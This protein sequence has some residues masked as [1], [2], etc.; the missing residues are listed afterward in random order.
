MSVSTLIVINLRGP[1]KMRDSYVGPFTIIKLV[2]KKEVEVNLTEE[3]SRKHPFFIVTL[4]KP[5]HQTDED[6]FPKSREVPS[7]GKVVGEYL[8]GQ[9]RRRLKA[10]KMNIN[11]KNHRKHLV[12]LKIQEEDKGKWIPGKKYLMDKSI[13][14]GQKSLISYGPFLKECLAR[15]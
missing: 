12:R 11:T 1:K 14:G 4:V 2:L 6:S 8:A 15:L 13:L 9:V 3:F 5:Y 7:A 10:R